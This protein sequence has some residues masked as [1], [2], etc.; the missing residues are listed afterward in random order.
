LELLRSLDLLGSLELL[1][2]LE[3]HA[4]RAR[5]SLNQARLLRI[6]HRLLSVL[7]L[8]L[9]PHHDHPGMSTAA[10][11]GPR[12]ASL[13]VGNRRGQKTS[14]TEGDDQRLERAGHDRT[15][16]IQF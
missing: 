16:W 13:D 6:G 4:D 15:P 3:L 14:A 10:V 8:R 5:L 7:N 2:P 12:M 9:S 1:R 11:T